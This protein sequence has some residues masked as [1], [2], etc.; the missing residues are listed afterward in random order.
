[1][2]KTAYYTSL[3]IIGSI[4]ISLSFMGKLDTFWNGVGSA[5]LLIGMIRLLKE[6]RLNKNEAYRQQVEIYTHDERYQFIRVKAMSWTTYYFIM[7]CAILTFVFYLL[8]Q[9][10]LSM[11]SS[12]AICIMLVIYW[13]CYYVLK[14]K[15]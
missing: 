14:K 5:L 15:Y 12:F 3:I 7:I 2:K 13:I 4:L 10:F 1:M 6:H 8:N 11:V 9:K